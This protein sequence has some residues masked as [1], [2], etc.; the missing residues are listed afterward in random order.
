MRRL[1]KGAALLWRLCSVSPVVHC[2]VNE[3]TFLS[4]LMKPCLCYIGFSPINFGFGSFLDVLN[5]VGG[6]CLA[7]CT[8]L[9]FNSII[10][11]IRNSLIFID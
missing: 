5:V 11:K 2:N 9:L 3:C 10:I 8:F 1:K 4:P 7:Q 6:T